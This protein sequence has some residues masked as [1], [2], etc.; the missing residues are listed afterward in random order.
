MIN[1]QLA[2]D[3]VSLGYTINVVPGY[4]LC[5]SCRVKINEMKANPMEADSSSD[6]GDQ[7]SMEMEHEISVSSSKDSVNATLTKLDLLP[8][9]LHGIAGTAKIS[10]GKRKLK[11]ANEALSR[12]VATALDV[13]EGDLMVAE[14]YEGPSLNEIQEKADDLDH[15]VFLMKEKLK[16]SNRRR[17]LQILTLTPNTW[18]LRKAAETF[19]VSKST[20][21]KARRLKAE[22]GILE[23][24]ESVKGRTLQQDTVDSVIAFYNDDEFTRQLPGKRDCVS[25][26]KKQYMSKRLILCD[27]KELYAAF[28]EKNPEMKISFS[29]FA[30]LRLAR[31]D[32]KGNI[33]LFSAARNRVQKFTA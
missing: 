19:R 22:K 18:S 24:P 4:M 31:H 28:K 7:L 21:Q 23:M 26:G 16:T 13:Q 8:F 20:I 17:K 32:F 3:M 11:Q 30:T 6:D 2:K 12:K 33:S 5:P 15:L 29:K 1:L 14:P 27:L 9:K 25:I 10:H